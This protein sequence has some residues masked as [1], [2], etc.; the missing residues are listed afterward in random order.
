MN[1]FAIIQLFLS[2]ASSIKAI[3]DAATSNKSVV[4]EI[5]ALSKPVADLLTKFG[6]EFFPKASPTIALVG[7]VIA[8]FD[9]NTTKWL[10]GALNVLLALDPPLRVD[11]QYGPKT[12]AAVEKLQT[13][14]GLV[15]DGLAGKIT[16]AAIATALA[17]LPVLK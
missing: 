17:K 12:K 5:T 10:Q 7:G 8:A 3:Y 14:L 9:P 13:K 4:D 6:Q 1:T 11:G 16:Q 15:V 2:S